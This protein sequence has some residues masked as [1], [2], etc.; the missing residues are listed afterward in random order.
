MDTTPFP[1]PCA[2]AL[3]DRDACISIQVIH[4]SLTL[5]EFLDLLVKPALE[6]LGYPHQLVEG[7]TLSE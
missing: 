3:Q 4:D 1:R 5:A 6:A 7:I 2:I